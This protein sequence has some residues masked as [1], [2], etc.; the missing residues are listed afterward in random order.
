MAQGG[1][2]S[3]LVLIQIQ[4]QIHEFFILFLNIEWFFQHLGQLAVSMTNKS[5]IFY[6][7][8]DDMCSLVWNER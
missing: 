5:G 2:R 7:M 4:E 8:I 6:P 3:I 1:T